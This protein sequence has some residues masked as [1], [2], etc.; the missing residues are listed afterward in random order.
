M[1]TTL[2]EVYAGSGG[3]SLGVLQA[4][5][6][7]RTAVSL[8]VAAVHGTSGTEIA[9]RYQAVKASAIVAVYF[10]LDSIGGA[11]RSNITMTCHVYNEHSS[12]ASRPG[13][14]SRQSVTGVA[15]PADDTW[16]KFD[17]S[18]SSYTPAIGEI[19]WPT[20][21]NTASAPGTDYPNILWDNAFTDIGSTF[22]PNMRTFSTTNGYSSDGSGLKKVAIIELA[23]GTLVA[24]FP[25]TL[26]TATAFTSNTLERGFVVEDL[27]NAVSVF[28]VSFFGTTSFNGLK[29][30]EGSTAPGGTA[31][32]SYNLGSDS[33]QNRD[34]LMG[35]LFTPITL[36]AYTK[37]RFVFTSSGSNQL[38]NCITLEGYSDF[39]SMFNKLYGRGAYFYAT[40]DN[41]AG[42]WTDSKNQLV[43]A[44]L[45]M[46]DLPLGGGFI[47]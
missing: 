12:S 15:C 22:S 11:T 42:G 37:Y 2:T 25:W 36:K 18:A 13:T 21:S 29:V 17:L 24:G 44:V 27:P 6:G 19:L 32:A 20:I 8:N 39:T 35:K 10:F 38:P 41:G 1:A 23:D 9:V 47:G 31:V 3:G 46:R 33:N 16:I 45:H 5:A 30:Y 34:E 43:R 40:Q 7:G 26:A 14:T 4:S 28:G